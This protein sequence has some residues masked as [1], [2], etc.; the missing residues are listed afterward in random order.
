MLKLRNEKIKDSKTVDKLVAG[1]L[2]KIDDIIKFLEGLR[3]FYIVERK[4]G[5]KH[6]DIV[7]SIGTDIWEGG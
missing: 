7:T 2:P 6:T 1:D 5:K 4:K 3:L